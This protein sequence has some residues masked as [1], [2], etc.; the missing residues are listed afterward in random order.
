MKKAVMILVCTLVL[1]GCVL[2][3]F[4]DSYKKM[5]VSK[6]DRMALLEEQLKGYHS[7]LADRRGGRA[8]GYIHD[9]QRDQFRS[10]LREIQK[11]ERIVDSEVD[12]VDFDEDA[13]EATAEVSIRSYQVPYYIVNERF[14][15]ET[16]KFSLASGWKLYSREV[17]DT[18]S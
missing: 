2:V 16:W 15:K 17:I 13:Y 10:V 5:G 1:N 14:E 9:E 12:F 18:A 8:L 3:P 11:K 4:I 6:T 7:A